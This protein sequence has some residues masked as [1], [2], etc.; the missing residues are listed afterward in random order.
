[1][2]NDYKRHDTA[3]LFTALDLLEGKVISRCMQATGIRNSFS[4]PSSGKCRPTRRS[5][6][7][8]TTMLHTSTPRCALGSHAIRPGRCP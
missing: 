6:W 1:M 4:M 8:S 2:T 3:T 7:S 5:M